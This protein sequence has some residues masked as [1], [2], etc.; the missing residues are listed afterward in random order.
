MYNPIYMII[1]HVVKLKVDENRTTV[2]SVLAQSVH[3][4]VYSS[5]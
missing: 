3:L 4:P 1:E 2:M 5:S